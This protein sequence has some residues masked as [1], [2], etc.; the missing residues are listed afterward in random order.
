VE[1]LDIIASNLT[2]RAVLMVADIESSGTRMPGTEVTLDESSLSCGAAF[3][4]ASA[5]P[6]LPDLFGADISGESG[7]RLY[8]QPDR[9]VIEVD[10]CFYVLDRPLEV[11][12]A[13]LDNITLM[14]E[15]HPNRIRS[16]TFVSEDGELLDTIAV[17]GDKFTYVIDPSASFGF[18]LA[19]P[20]QAAPTTPV[21]IIKPIEDDPEPR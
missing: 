11:D 20:G 12:F 13:G 5:Y 6:S 3:D 9:G 15:L 14:F 7:L 2:I 19:E 18:E 16:R 8:L 17:A 21:V 10:E 4:P 1:I